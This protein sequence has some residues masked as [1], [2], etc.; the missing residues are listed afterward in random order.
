MQDRTQDV[1]RGRA[2]GQILIILV[3]A[4]LLVNV[5]LS[6]RGAGLIHSIPEATAVIIYDGMALKG[7][8]PEIY[9]LED[10][11]LRQ[12][13]SSDT[14]NYFRRR[15]RLE[16]HSVDDDILAQFGRGRAIRRLVKCKDLPTIYALENGQ[17]RRADIL[18]LSSQS[19]PWD[20]IGVVSCKYLRNMPNGPPVFDE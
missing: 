14:F 11:K 6:Y 10:H 9:L 4:V 1:R 7:S 16:I 19:S 2:L 15:H 18:S 8:G 20:D 12:F 17:K 3:V 13:S 5:P